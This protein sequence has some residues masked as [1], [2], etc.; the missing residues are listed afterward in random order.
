M[1]WRQV[2]MA[3]AFAGNVVNFI[4]SM[5]HP[6]YFT[7]LE[8]LSCMNFWSLENASKRFFSQRQVSFHLRTFFLLYRLVFIYVNNIIEIT[9]SA[10]QY[11]S[12]TFS[13]PTFQ[14]PKIVIVLLIARKE[15]FNSHVRYFLSFG[16]AILLYVNSW[17]LFND[18]SRCWKM[19]YLLK[20]AVFS[21]QSSSC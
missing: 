11:F 9:K 14:I 21:S 8:F 19:T 7:F 2:I 1:T 10:E 5:G 18:L 12:I 17:T 6:I 13:K 16:K 20:N 4:T 15:V 3:S